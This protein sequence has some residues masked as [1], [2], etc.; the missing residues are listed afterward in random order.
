LPLDLKEDKL[1]DAKEVTYEKDNG[2]QSEHFKDIV[3][4][5]LLENLVVVYIRVEIC[6]FIVYALDC[7]FKAVCINCLY[8]FAK[9]LRLE[10]LAGFPESE[11]LQTNAETIIW[12]LFVA[13]ISLVVSHTAVES[14]FIFAKVYERLK[15]KD[16]NDV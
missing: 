13:E 14:L 10:Q 12:V 15:G 16:C 5:Y 9:E 11:Q 8:N 4:L 6:S 7:F 1:E 2:G 3:N